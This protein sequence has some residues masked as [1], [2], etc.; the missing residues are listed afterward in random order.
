MSNPKEKEKVKEIETLEELRKK[1]EI[2][3]ERIRREAIKRVE[4]E[5]EVESINI[6]SSLDENDYYDCIDDADYINDDEDVEDYYTDY[7]GIMVMLMM[8]I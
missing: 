8:M 1:L 5:I 4:R 3:I 6:I 7:Y 2:E